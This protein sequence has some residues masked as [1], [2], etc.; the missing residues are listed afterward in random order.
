MVR[1]ILEE[2]GGIRNGTCSCRKRLLLVAAFAFV[3][4]LGPS[5][6]LAQTRGE[7]TVTI[8]DPQIVE[9]LNDVI[10]HIGVPSENFLYLILVRDNGRSLLVSD[11]EWEDLTMSSNSVE[12]WFQ[13]DVFVGWREWLAT[14]DNQDQFLPYAGVAK[15]C[16]ACDA[17]M[18]CGRLLPRDA[19]KQ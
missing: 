16:K 4:L 18:C 7:D 8:T 1:G 13:L 19:A 3:V 17:T 5:N 9:K 10:E 12:D 2:A 11:R 14:R 15:A 6:V